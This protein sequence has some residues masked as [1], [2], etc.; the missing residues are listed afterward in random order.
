[1]R[2]SPSFFVLF[3]I[4]CLSLNSL[5]RQIIVRKPPDVNQTDYEIQLDDIY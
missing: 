2:V 1:M 3:K 5:N 4:F